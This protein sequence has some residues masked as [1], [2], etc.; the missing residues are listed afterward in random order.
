[1][2]EIKSIDIRLLEP[3]KGQI[4]GLPKNPRFIRDEKYKKLL[5]SMREHPLL[6]ELRELIVY[7]L[8]RKGAGKQKESYVV[9][10]GNQRL[11]ALQ[12]AGDKVVV[13]KVLPED[14]TV[15]QIKAYVLKANDEYGQWDFDALANQYGNVDLD[16]WGLDLTAWQVKEQDF[17]G[18][19]VEL[20]IT[21][22]DETMK[23][24]IKADDS[25]YSDIKRGLASI[26]N[27]PEMAL[28]EVTGWNNE[29]LDI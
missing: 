24:E 25:L 8:C 13:C 7:P 17:D 29:M 28:L 14:T 4:E 6:S 10:D 5:K 12:D 11:R 23:L 26:N 20:D 21:D 18:A 2:V 3:N 9:C 15:E 16:E 22:F 1:M 19:G 27:S